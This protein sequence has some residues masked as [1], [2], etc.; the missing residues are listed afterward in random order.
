MSPPT[1]HDLFLATAERHADKPALARVTDGRIERWLSWR[2]LLKAVAH[3]QSGLKDFAGKEKHGALTPARHYCDIAWVT[4]TLAVHASG[5]VLAPVDYPAEDLRYSANLA[6]LVNTAGTGTAAKTVM[7]SHDNLASNAL[8]LSQA[9][10]GD[11]DELRLSFL[12]FEHLYAR[13]GDLFTW[14]VRGS[15]LVIAENPKTVFRDA[16]LVKPTVING[17]PYFFQKAIDRAQAERVSLKQLLGCEI[18]RLYCGGA[19]LAPAIEA[20]FADEGIPIYCGYGLTEASPVVSVN[21]PEAYKRGTVGRPLPG[22]EVRIAEDG[23]VLVRGP[24]VMLGYWNNPAATAETLREGWLHTGDLGQLDSEGFLTIVGRK[25]EL[26]VLSTGKKVAPA[27]VEAR[28]G[29]SPWIEQACVFGEGHTGLTALI[30]PNADRLRAEIKSRRLWVWS[31]RQ[32]L[33]HA[34]IRTLY[35]R[36]ID[37]CLANAPAEERVHAFRLVGRGFDPARGEMTAK[38]SLRRPAI[39]KSFAREIAAMM[40]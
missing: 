24:N 2:D 40:R 26:L 13:T 12:P 1:I 17:V 37:I 35:R 20:R 32:A 28:L 11:G 31:K 25:K 21:T 39:A 36:E 9:S 27:S 19:S 30:V 5:R 23:E 34:V 3:E 10:G 22:V 18:K 33:G 16:R 4:H 15:R 6:A 29:A 14:L 38:L 8:A 7:L